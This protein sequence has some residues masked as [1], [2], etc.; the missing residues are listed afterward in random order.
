MQPMTV[1]LVASGG[2]VATIR[3]SLSNRGYSLLVAETAAAGEDRLRE[4]GI[5]VVVVEYEIPGGIEAFAQALERLPDPPPF[6]L[7]AGT[8]EAPVVSARLGAAA[9]LTKPLSADDL[10]A[11][12]QRMIRAAPTTSFDDSP[13]GPLERPT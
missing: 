6:V 10:I 1:L 5:D 9:L 13:T 12:L 11:V 7:V 4:G 3:D 8:A 2:T